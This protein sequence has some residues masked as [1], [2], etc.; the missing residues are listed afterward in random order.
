VDDRVNDRVYVHQRLA[1]E[2]GGRG[3][4]I[5]LL[6]TRWAPHLERR[7]GVRLFGI[8]ATVGSTGE[9]PE[10]RVQWEVDDWAHWGRAQAGQVPMEERDVFLTELWAQALELRTSGHTM[11]LEPAPCS[12]DL[13]TI[14]AAALAPEVVLH[15]DVRSRPGLMGEYHR[16]LEAEL[17]P[18]AE[19]R[20]LRLLGA[21][22]HALVPNIGVNLWAL[23]DWD[24]W[25]ALMEAEPDDPEMRAWTERQAA[26]LADLDGF[27]VVPPPAMAL[28]T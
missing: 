23:P 16:A 27:L 8:W 6:R 17:V 28:R 14:T 18:L 1:I 2:G 15:E 7:Y 3:A 19:A 13:A 22:R 25:R 10:V 24:H 21:Y 9:W 4:M 20:G 12:P 5:E 11:L 26:W